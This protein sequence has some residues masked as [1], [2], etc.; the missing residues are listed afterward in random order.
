MTKKLV[1]SAK[2]YAKNVTKHVLRVASRSE[3][4]RD[5]LDGVLKDTKKLK[6]SFRDPSTTK[7]REQAIRMTR[8][9]RVAY[10]SKSYTEA[11]KFFKE[12]IEIDSTYALGYTYLGHTKYKQGQHVDAVKF[13]KKAIDA[14]PNSP[15]AAKARK[16]IQHVERLQT[17]VSEELE[18]RLR[19]HH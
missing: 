17:S 15:A 10:N 19:N 18:K 5:A 4:T 7:A 12:A 8:N 9:G 3:T 6:R 11:E 2:S 14:E 13:W 16:K 1:S